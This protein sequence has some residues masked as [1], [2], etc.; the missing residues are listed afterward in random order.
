M[1]TIYIILSR[2]ETMVSHL[3]GIFTSAP[4]THVSI[5]FE[6]S[7]CP[8]Y[9]FARLGTLPLPGGIKLEYTDKGY[10]K[11]HGH[12]PCALYSLNVPEEVYFKA[13][14]IAESMM[15]EHDRY[16]YNV[17]GLFLCKLNIAMSRPYHYFCSE[18]VSNVLERSHAVKLPKHPSLMRPSD[19]MNL[20]G[21]NLVFKGR[22][23]ELASQCAVERVS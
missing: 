16:T 1:K 2:S 3:I 18:F 4:Y 17:M 19:Y 10:Y 8:M 23:H 15:A 6:E 9:S 12:I 13:R 20:P 14:C 21:V 22:M 5:A 7:L 11:D